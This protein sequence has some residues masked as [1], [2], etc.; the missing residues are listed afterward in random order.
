MRHQS[1]R[2]RPALRSLIAGGVSNNEG[3][4]DELDK[5]LKFRGM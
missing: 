1:L 5:I 4:V 3:E 2:N